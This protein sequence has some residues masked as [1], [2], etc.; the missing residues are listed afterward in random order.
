VPY[1]LLVADGVLALPGGPMRAAL[2]CDA[3][4]I[5]AIGREVE[6]PAAA[7]L[8]AQGLTV[9]P[10][11]VEI[12]VHGGGGASFLPPGPG[13]LERYA[14]WAP[15]HGV[16]AFAA[17]VAAP[18]VESL[19]AALQL[20]FAGS[21]EG[22][23]FLGFHLEGPF[24]NPARRGA[25]PAEWL[26]LPD[27]GLFER[28]AE[29]AGGRLRMM[30]VAPELP[31]AADVARAAE[32]AGV[33]LALGHTDA[34]F[35]QAADA[36]QGAFTHVTHLFNA[37]RPFH[38]R[39]GGPVAAA[40]LSG[41]TCELIA[42]GEHVAPEVLRL[43]YRVLGPSRAVL[44]SDAVPASGPGP[45]ARTADGTIAGSLL[46]FDEHARRAAA[47]LGVDVSALVRLCSANP[48]RAL[49]VHHRK[50]SIE[51]GMDADLVL[52]DR[53]LRV[54]ATVCRGRVAFLSEPHRF[55]A[56]PSR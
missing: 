23:D 5:V 10:G 21:P 3:N 11:F 50:G 45:I 46:P 26:T 20:P 25:F 35:G 7:V 2:L 47:L 38:H 16:T 29:A 51:R 30:T 4:R 8:D 41:A 39:D 28:L 37:M 14:R 53:E 18:S 54:V 19:V 49:G 1:R 34:S 33:V 43:A 48:A 40:L 42:D 44:V 31:G 15:A 12:H 27:R 17:S 55:R 56:A 32:E 52:L 13:A 22:A 24:L 9:A 6:D 36:L